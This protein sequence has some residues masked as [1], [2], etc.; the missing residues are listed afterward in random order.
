MCVHVIVLLH[1]DLCVSVVCV[2]TYVDTSLHQCI[3]LS[4]QS[5]CEPGVL[6]LF[7]AYVR[8]YTWQ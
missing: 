7:C 2:C 3:Y 5:A 8:T 4:L 1:L 6:C